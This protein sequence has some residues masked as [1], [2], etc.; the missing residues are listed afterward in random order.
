MQF[1][2]LISNNKTAINEER[3]LNLLVSCLNNIKSKNSF[4]LIVNAIVES[5]LKNTDIALKLFLNIIN[6]NNE[7]S[8]FSFV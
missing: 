6:S 3:F 1:N 2:D 4:L 5:S 7:K 8:E